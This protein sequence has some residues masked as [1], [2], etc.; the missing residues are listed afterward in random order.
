MRTVS[1][2]WRVWFML[3]EGTRHLGDVTRVFLAIAIRGFASGG[4]RP[5]AAVFPHRAKVGSSPIRGLIRARR[6]Q[7][8]GSI[9]SAA[10]CGF[11]IPLRPPLLGSRH[12]VSHCERGGQ[13][14]IRCRSIL[15]RPGRLIGV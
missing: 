9:S 7:Y 6:Y 11:N 12:V 14:G 1:D 2:P 10:H 13:V 15:G 5:F 8:L 3:L 4:P